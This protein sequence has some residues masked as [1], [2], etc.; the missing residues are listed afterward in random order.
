MWTHYLRSTFFWFEYCVNFWSLPVI[1]SLWFQDNGQTERIVDAPHAGVSES[2]EYTAQDLEPSLVYGVVDLFTELGIES[3]WEGELHQPLQKGLEKFSSNLFSGRQGSFEELNILNLN[4]ASQKPLL[5]GLES[6][7]L[8]PQGLNNKNDKDGN[9]NMFKP[10]QFASVSELL[11]KIYYNLDPKYEVFY[12]E[13]HACNPSVE[14]W[15]H[16]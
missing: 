1:I 13:I 8:K 10:I 16:N 3:N 11:K 4:K 15:F 12:I 9:S 5:F 14:N 2:S 7:V 6:R